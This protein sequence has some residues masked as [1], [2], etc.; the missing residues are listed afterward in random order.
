MAWTKPRGFC[1]PKGVLDRDCPL[2]FYEL[3]SRIPP[4]KTLETWPRLGFLDIMIARIDLQDRRV[5]CFL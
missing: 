3:L 1:G 4:G 2:P 5:R